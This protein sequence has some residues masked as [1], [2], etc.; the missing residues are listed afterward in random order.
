MTVNTAPSLDASASPA[1]PIL[2]ENATNPAGITVASL[3]VNGS[4][5]D[6]DGAVEAI[7]I[8]ALNTSLGS[9]QYSL[10]SGATWLTIRADLI[11]SS[12]NELAL[13]L[14][15][16]ASI[17]LLPFGELNGTLSAAITFRAWDQSAG[18]QGQYVA[19]L[20]NGG[21]SAFSAASDT[22]SL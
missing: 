13:L 11:D 16:T 9:W 5:T 12:T 2:L 4:I 22:A 1:L 7:A 19:I 14:G 20:A 8:T 18:S 6:A 17:R 21:T 10:D 3:M 15:A